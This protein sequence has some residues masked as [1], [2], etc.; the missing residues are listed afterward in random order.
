MKYTLTY[1]GEGYIEEFAYVVEQ[2]VGSES[3]YRYADESDSFLQ[4]V[5]KRIREGDPTL[6]H[7]FY[8]YVLWEGRDLEETMEWLRRDKGFST[9]ILKQYLGK[10]IS[11]GWIKREF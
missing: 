5:T 11:E 4:I 6:L 1:K 2:L 3:D 10:A 9:T 8:M 7:L